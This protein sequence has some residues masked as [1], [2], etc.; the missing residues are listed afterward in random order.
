M[1]IIKLKIEDITLYER[2]AKKHT[3]EQIDHIV[4]SIK[5]FGFNDPVGVWGEKNIC[6]EGHGRILALKQMGEIEVDAIRLDH[7]TDEERRAYTLAHNQTTLETSFDSE[8]LNLELGDI[9][10]DMSDFGFEPVF[11]PV[12]AEE[13]DF[14]IEAELEKIV[15]PIARV[16]D[17][18]QLGRHRLICGDS[19]EEVV[20]N[21]LLE[22]VEADLLLTDPPY[23]VNY[24]GCTKDRLKM[25]NDKQSDSAYKDF[26]IK[27]LKNAYK[28]LRPGG[29]FY[30]FHADSEGLTVRQAS[31]I[32]GFMPRQCLIWLKNSLVIGRQD[33]QWKHEPC[34]FGWKEGAAHKWYGDRKQTTILEFDR[35]TVNAEHPTMKPVKLFDYLMQNS[36]AAKERILDIF[37]GSG[38]TIIACEQNGRI[39]YCVEKDR[40]YCDVII[41]RWETL[42]GQ[43]AVLIGGGA[44][45]G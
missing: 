26:L 5:K 44:D 33:Y 29:V 14:D 25:E 10:L 31:S 41:K 3:K 1:E 13:D 39:A 37:A 42:T 34:L 45:A 4:N 9:N 32:S 36:S 30:L 16:G 23:N 2:N 17:I 21:K 35:P 7:L 24:E 28:H 43:K 20:I 8:L 12:S 15:E 27:S 6:I 40:K 18:W 11:L 22:G 38:T 19:T